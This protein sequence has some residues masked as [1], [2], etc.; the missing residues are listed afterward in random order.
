MHP[1][2]RRISSTEPDHC[3]NI[4]P[5]ITKLRRATMHNRR[6]NMPFGVF[7]A[8]CLSILPPQV[9]AQSA[10][11]TTAELSQRA[12]IIAVGKVSALQARWEPNKSAI[13]TYVT[14][15]VGEYLKGNAGQSIVI[16]SPG[17]EIDG[18]GEY[19]SHSS[20]FTRDEEVV[21]FA[22]HDAH[23]R[24]R[25]TGG[26]NGKLT[27]TKD[28]D[29]GVSVVADHLRLEEFKSKISTSIKAQ[30]EP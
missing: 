13:V 18:V 27:I 9:L 8:V 24:L 2:H 25:V 17:G 30:V 22:D 12:E 7:V 5:S 20:R 23:G 10:E 1:G 26:Q 3:K 28:A 15:S 21:V 11:A 4:P 14:L 16:A 6:H 19:Y 29:T